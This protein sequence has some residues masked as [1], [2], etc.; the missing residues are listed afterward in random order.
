[1]GVKAHAL[2]ELHLA[3]TKKVQAMT[4]MNQTTRIHP[5]SPEQVFSSAEHACEETAKVNCGPAVIHLCERVGRLPNMYVV[6]A[7]SI[8]LQE[9]GSD[10]KQLRTTDFAT[11]VG[12][13]RL[14]PDCLE[15]VYGVHYEMDERGGGHPIF[16][17]QMRPFDEFVEA[18][19]KHFHM[20]ARVDDHVGKVLRNVRIPTS[21]M[22][23]FSVLTQICADHLMG[24]N[25]PT[26]DRQISQA[27][28]RVRTACNFMQGAAHRFPNLSSGNAPECYRSWRWYRSS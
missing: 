18:I 9:S 28:D 12:Y 20:E 7:G 24:L 11:R 8:C 17:S 23:F 22:D 19:N 15:H 13:F 25:P 27:F 4:A 2:K 10:G 1:M 16:H 26:A 14:K 3:W 5:F 21:Q 6:L